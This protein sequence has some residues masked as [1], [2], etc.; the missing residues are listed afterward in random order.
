ME[1]EYGDRARVFKAFCD[2]TRLM[3]LALLQE[4]E[5]CACVLL[6]RLAI[7]QPTLSYHMKILADSGVVTARRAG[8]WTYYSLSG[9]GIAR[10]EAFLREITR[11]GSGRLSRKDLCPAGSAGN[12]CCR[13][14]R[15]K[16]NVREGHHPCCL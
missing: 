13:G 6:E 2:E 10:A 12:G 14:G 11:P 4:G 7:P 1:G 5:E 8:K 16:H 15:S 3:V 9:E